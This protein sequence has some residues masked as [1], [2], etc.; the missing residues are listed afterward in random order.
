MSFIRNIGGKI[1]R[2]PAAAFIALMMSGHA[3]LAAQSMDGGAAGPAMAQQVHKLKITVPVTNVAGDMRAGE[4]EWGYS[5]L[6]EVDGHRILYDTGASADMV[7]RNARA[8]HVDLSDV[9]DVVLSHNHWDHVGGLMALRR[10]FAK[11]NARAMSRVH[12]GAGIFEPRLNAAGEDSNGL[13][14]IRAEYLATGGAFI[15][16]DSPTELFPGVWFTGPVPR[17]NPE[18]NWNPGLFLAA[19]Q[20]RVVFRYADRLDP[21]RNAYSV[22]G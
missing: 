6:V 7:L 14:L 13:R 20:G 5:A 19:P 8:L 18:R 9:E 1:L 17:P 16:H 21:G 12:V 15:V 11:S 22:V 3:S 4:G 2:R 10:E